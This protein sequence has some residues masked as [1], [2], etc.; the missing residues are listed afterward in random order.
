VDT[1]TVRAGGVEELPESHRAGE[2][3]R[4]IGPGMLLLFVVG[5]I[6]GAGIYARVGAVAAEVGG[7][8]WA[9]FLLGFAIA[10]LTAFSYGELSS[11]YP[12]AG[13]AA[14]FIHKAFR[15]PV[16][17]FLVA[18]AVLAS[19]ISSASAVAR[20]FGGRYLQEFVTVP[21]VPI[22]LLFIVLVALINLRGI[23]ESVGVNMVLTLIELSGLLLIVLIGIVALAGGTGD[24][25]RAFTFKEGANVPL[26]I[27]AG[28][29]VAF[30]AFLGFEDAAN[31]AE[32]T[33]DPVR[34]MPRALLGGLGLAALVYLVVSFTAAMVVDTETLAGSSGPLL[35]VV[36]AGPVP[37]PPKLFSL[38]A[39]LAV[40][41]TALINMIMGS[42]L[43]YG[44]A[45]QGIVPRVFGR[46]H[47]TRQTPWVAIAF[48][49]ALALVLVATGDIGDLANT[50]V[51]LLLAVFSLVNIV[52]LVLRRDSVGHDHFTVPSWVPVLGA[53]TCLA[54]LSR[55]QGE[56]F[57]RAGVLLLVGLV[58]WGINEII[59]RRGETAAVPKPRS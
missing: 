42:R 48:T 40:A 43:L 16:V 7:A 24:P 59:S 35:E 3:K 9:S 26:A 21:E 29:V 33:R 22:A 55:Q 49:T 37:V 25:G 47:S 18:F 41:N 28:T 30:Y 12:G 54:L 6:L 39:L 10:V 11:K 17:T 51:A 45:E 19:G 36:K 2:L 38:V 4:A 1:T 8:I 32:E 44:M 14:L 52:V 20:A 13:G 31:V 50:T 57:L 53:V 46:T 5:D 58:L 15:R 34:M 56:I 27:L 23:S